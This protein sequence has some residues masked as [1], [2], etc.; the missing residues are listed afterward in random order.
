MH[1]IE[2]RSSFRCL[3]G[4]SDDPSSP[5]D[6]AEGQG[7]VSGGREVARAHEL[8]DVRATHPPQAHRTT[9]RSDGSLAA[10]T[11]AISIDAQSPNHGT[12]TAVCADG[13]LWI[14]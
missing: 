11:P 1:A 3:D 4:A 2:R 6:L 5:P 9:L 8:R 14:R 13:E 12:R 7:I 10:P